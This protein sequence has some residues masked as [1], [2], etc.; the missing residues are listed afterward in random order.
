MLWEE[1]G[2]VLFLNHCFETFKWEKH[3]KGLAI[4]CKVLRSFE[5]W[6]GGT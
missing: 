1:K 2:F 6:Q 3:G 4:S 5:F